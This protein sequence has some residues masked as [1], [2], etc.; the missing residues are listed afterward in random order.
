M[1]LLVNA[2]PEDSTDLLFARF[3]TCRDYRVRC[4]PFGHQN[5]TPNDN[6]VVK[7]A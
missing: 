1:I 5:Q 3:R 2:Q 4:E 7:L 6:E